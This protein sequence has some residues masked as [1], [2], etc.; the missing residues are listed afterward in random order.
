MNSPLVKRAV[1]C[2]DARISIVSNNDKLIR[3]KRY[4]ESIRVES[5]RTNV[6]E[7]REIPY[8]DVDAEFVVLDDPVLKPSVSIGRETCVASGD[9]TAWEKDCHDIRYSLFGNLGLFFRYSLSVLERACGIYSFHA[10]SIY[11]P[12]TNTLLLVM[13]GPG[14]GKT[15]YLLRAVI[16]GLKIFSTEMTHVRLTKD[17]IDFYKGSLLDNV[18]LGSLV[19]DFPQVVDIL[20]LKLPEVEDAWQEQ[21]TI[22]LSTLQADDIYRNPRLQIINAHI[23]SNRPKADVSVMSDR[24]TI[25]WT[26]FKNASEKFAP[27]WLMYERLPVAGCD[28][29]DLARRRLD[30]MRKF[31]DKADL[32]PIKSIYSGVKNCMEGIEY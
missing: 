12:T 14:A 30:T 20:G 16:E 31:I 2:V 13:G 5:L 29:Q 4:F 15:V 11:I 8:E 22:D 18:R 7:Y 6:L 27:P 3:P 32:L 17:G 1:Q 21:M 25:V 9:F 26:L 28:D 23:E 19:Y 10:S 24:D